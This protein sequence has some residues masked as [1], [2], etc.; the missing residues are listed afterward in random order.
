MSLFAIS[1]KTIDINEKF[2]IVFI[3]LAY[4]LFICCVP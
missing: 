2:K 4:F 3:Y 1:F